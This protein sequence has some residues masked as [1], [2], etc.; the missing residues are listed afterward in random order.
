[1]FSI[2]VYVSAFCCL[3]ATDSQSQHLQTYCLIWSI[4]IFLFQWLIHILIRVDC[5]TPFGRFLGSEKYYRS[6]SSRTSMV[7][8]CRRRRQLKVDL[9]IKSK[10]RSTTVWAHRRSSTLLARSSRVTCD[11]GFVLSDGP[12]LVKTEMVVGGDDCTN[13]ERR[14]SARIHQ[15]SFWCKQGHHVGDT[16]FCKRCRDSECDE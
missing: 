10:R 6:H 3:L 15:V 13:I 1:M 16:G 11:M 14:Q 12:A 9:W 5:P 2:F 4:K 8:L 7:E